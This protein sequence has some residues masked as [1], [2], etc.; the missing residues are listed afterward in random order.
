MS[1]PASSVLMDDDRVRVTRYDFAPGDETG[2]HVHDMEY[3]IVTLTDCR[4]RL[5]LPGGQT[6]DSTIP[7]GSAYSQPRGTEHN[8]ANGGAAPMSFIEVELK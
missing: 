4:L 1:T 5:D 7:A 8:V 2:W 3:V 6:T